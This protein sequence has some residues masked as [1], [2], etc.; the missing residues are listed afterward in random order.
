MGCAEGQEEG[1]AERSQVRRTLPRVMGFC[2]RWICPFPT[3]GLVSVLQTLKSSSNCKN[4]FSGK[5]MDG[6]QREEA[7]CEVCLSQLGLLYKIFQTGGFINRPLLL[8]V[9]EAGKSKIKVQIGFLVRTLFLDRRQLPSCCVFTWPFLVRAH[10]E[11]DF[12]LPLLIRIPPSW[13]HLRLMASE[14][15]YLQIPSHWG[16]GL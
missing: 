16:L 2:C 15:P 12:C 13:P 5:H 7:Y 9:L 8:T 1:K 4:R 3:G 11:R 10:G 14:R 6:D